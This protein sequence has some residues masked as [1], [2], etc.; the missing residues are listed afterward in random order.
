MPVTLLG[1][2]QVEEI[3]LVSCV[4]RRWDGAR[5]WWPNTLLDTCAHYLSCFRLSCSL[6]Q[7][8]PRCSV[9]AAVHE[10]EQCCH[11]DTSTL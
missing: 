4:V 11:A 3:A 1:C 9:Q 8:C 6:V 10:H 5:I 2:L 7:R